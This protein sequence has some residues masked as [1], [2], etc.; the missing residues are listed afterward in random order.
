MELGTV[1]LKFELEYF[2]QVIVEF[3]KD[4][5]SRIIF[6]GEFIIP[7]KSNLSLTLGLINQSYSEDIFKRENNLIFANF[8]FSKHLGWEF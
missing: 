1:S 2:E 8:S 6:L 7:L 4:S 3:E 5:L